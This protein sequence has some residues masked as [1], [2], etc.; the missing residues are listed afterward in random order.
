[1]KRRN[2][3]L[4]S[5]YFFPHW[6]GIAQAFLNLA[7][8][9]QRSGAA[10]TVLTVRFK[11]D[12]APREVLEGIEIRRSRY[13]FM[14]SRTQYS[15]TMILDAALLMLRADTV[16]I[17]SPFSNILF[18]SLLARLLGK[19][20]VIYHQGDLLLSRRADAAWKCAVVE[21]L[22][23]VFTGISMRLAHV[24]STY[25]DDY[26]RHSRVMRG[27]LHKFKPYIAP[28]ARPEP[29][30]VS[31]PKLD[32]LRSRFRLVGFA[33]RFVD[34]KGF[35]VLLRAIPVVIQQ[36]PGV[37]FVFAGETKIHYENCF[38]LNRELYERAQDHVSL[39]GL[40]RGDELRAFYSA[41]E[42]FVL[43]SRSD[44]FALTQAEAA[45]HG[46]ALVVSDIPGARVLVRAAACG[47]LVPPEDPE[48]LAEG[49]VHVLRNLA[50][51]RGRSADVSNFLEQHA[52]PPLD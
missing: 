43:P 34:E 15:I 32:D 21:K 1:M 40:L 5:E 36:E 12:L 17:N 28:F 50:E 38:E 23:D 30:G 3:L 42:V 33:G 22:F 8:Q 10:V 24:V 45:L 29:V 13:A 25:S 35:D 52:I 37:H 20:L 48:K 14:I 27:Q 41:L 18:V 44:C 6:T 19:R 49:I 51:Y 16:V 7:R 11:H 2:V 39:L 47:V 26:A 4:V 9:L 31:M 46:A